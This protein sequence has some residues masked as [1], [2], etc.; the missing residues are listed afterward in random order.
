MLNHYF[1]EFFSLSRGYGLAITFFCGS[2]YYFLKALENQNEKKSFIIGILFSIITI[3]SNLSMLI[4]IFALIIA[5][6]ASVVQSN[7]KSWFSRWRFAII[8][9]AAIALLPAMFWLY[10]LNERGLL[11]FGGSTGFVEDTFFSVINNYFLPN[12]FDNQNWVL[13]TIFFVTFLASILF[14]PKGKNRSKL[15][16]IL[17]IVW[18]ATLTPIIL[19]ISLGVEYP[20]G[21]TA[22]YWVVIMAV[23]LS[24]FLE[25]LY[26]STS[27]NLKYILTFPLFCFCTLISVGFINVANIK[28]THLARYDADTRAML[29]ILNNTVDKEK[30]IE[31][32]IDWRHEPTINYYRITKNYDWLL[33]ANQ[34]GFEYKE[35]DYYYIWQ[36]VDLNIDCQNEISSFPYSETKL[37]QNCNR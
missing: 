3:Y 27:K 12:L 28:F 2:V 20:A 22:L 14:N 15:V 25:I 17:I 37:I 11:Y 19:H 29:E 4:P 6:L 5:Y 34:E 8:G 36:S 33:P 13:L 9:L 31:I 23:F 18:L 21:R 16:F 26:E 10:F 32:G 35:Y 7:P 30:I 1:V 24:T